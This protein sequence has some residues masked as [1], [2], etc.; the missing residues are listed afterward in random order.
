MVESTLTRASTAGARAS[1]SCATPV[2]AGFVGFLAQ[3][4]F[5]PLLVT[6]II[7]LVVTIIGIPLLVLVPVV[8]VG[9]LVVMVLGF[10]GV[11]Q[12]VGRRW[13]R[14]GRQSA[15]VLF[16]IGLLIVMAPTLFGEALGLLSGPFG[17]FAV[18][19]GIVGFVVE[20]VAWTTGLGAV[21]LNRFGGE[22][23]AAG[24]PPLPIPEP[25]AETTPPPTASDDSV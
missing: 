11:A 14:A 25:Q 17:F 15:F 13:G 18:M 24:A 20:Y 21:I 8:L 1:N 2:K 22:P 23:A 7:L 10:T 9:A 6:G 5:L 19:L 3:L 16:W 4:L 12:G